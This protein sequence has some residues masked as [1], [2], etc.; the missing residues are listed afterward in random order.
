MEITGAKIKT[1]IFRCPKCGGEM[2]YT[3]NQK[4]GEKML[5]E[6]YCLS[7]DNRIWLEVTYPHIS[8][9]SYL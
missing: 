1:I 5:Y 7:C 8:I 9:F 2:K 6:H 4:P 3:T